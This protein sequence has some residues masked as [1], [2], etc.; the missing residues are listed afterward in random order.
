MEIGN[1]FSKLAIRKNG[2]DIIDAIQNDPLITLLPIDPKI[3]ETGWNLFR[4]RSDKKWGMVDYI[5]F[6]VMKKLNL[7]QALTADIHFEQ[8]GFTALLRD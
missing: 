1:S 7:R 8:A 6:V 3:D 5:S 4:N 2:V